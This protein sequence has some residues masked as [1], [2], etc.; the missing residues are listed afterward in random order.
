MS[1]SVQTTTFVPVPKTRV[2][3]CHKGKR[4]RIG[5]ARV[6]RGS[7]TGFLATFQPV[8]RRAP[9]RSNGTWPALHSE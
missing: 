6:R 3:P 8:Y 7:R 2:L 9:A 4:A 5:R 1:H